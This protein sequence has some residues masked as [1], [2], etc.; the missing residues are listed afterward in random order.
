MYIQPL[1]SYYGVQYTNYLPPK[2][3]V[4]IELKLRNFSKEEKW[5]DSS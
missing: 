5:Q 4:A 1:G 2:E 3:I